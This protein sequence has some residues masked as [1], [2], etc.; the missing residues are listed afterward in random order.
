M[1]RSSWTRIM[2]INWEGK[3]PGCRPL[4]TDAQ[5][6]GIEKHAN[7]DPLTEKERRKLADANR[8]L[9]FCLG[10]IKFCIKY[11]VMVSFENPRGSR[12][13]LTKS[14]LE[15]ADHPSVLW[16]TAS[17]C[18]YGTPW[19]KN[20]HFVT[21]NCPDFA[22]RTCKPPRGTSRSICTYTKKPHAELIGKSSAGEWETRKAQ[23]YPP[24]LCAQIATACIRSFGEEDYLPPDKL[25]GSTAANQVQDKG[26]LSRTGDSNMSRSTMS[27]E[28][29]QKQI[30]DG[31]EEYVHL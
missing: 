17:Y 26:A 2:D 15:V 8:L 7:G 29:I 31:L 11:G 6:M 23:S 13:F 18:Q 25:P 19:R 9:S 3:R 20:T 5:P 27:A 12:V 1:P 22:L 14:F 16:Q 30:D 21:W 4:R 24:G 28:T 10:V